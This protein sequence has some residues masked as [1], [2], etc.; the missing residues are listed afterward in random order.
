[1]Q[2]WPEIKRVSRID[3]SGGLA[4]NMAWLYG[5]IGNGAWLV[6]TIFF[7]ITRNTGIF[8]N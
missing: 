2:I 6:V 1:M 4:T 5:P 3:A 7:S 8:M